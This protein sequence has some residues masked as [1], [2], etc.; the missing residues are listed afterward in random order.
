[1]TKISDDNSCC[2]C[3]LDGSKPCR[4][5]NVVVLL[6]RFVYTNVISVKTDFCSKTSFNCCHLAFV[7]RR[8]L[9]FLGAFVELRKADCQLRHVRPS[10][11]TPGTTRLPLD[12]IFMNFFEYFSK[13]CRE[14]SDF[15]KIW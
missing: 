11:R 6:F 10:I 12:G 8:S 9:M 5:A 4:G 2:S 13:P 7:P 1:M 14:Y 15:I 3:V